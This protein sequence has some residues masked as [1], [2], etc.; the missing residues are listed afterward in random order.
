MMHKDI[1]KWFKL[2]FSMYAREEDISKW[3]PEGKNSI[4]IRQI[5]GQEFIFTYKSKNDWCFETIKHFSSR[6][7]ERR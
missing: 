4:R 2:Y 5:N 3:F 1:Y 6:S 7:K